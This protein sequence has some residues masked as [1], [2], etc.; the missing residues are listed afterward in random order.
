MIKSLA[1]QAERP[2]IRRK[3]TA[4]KIWL[5]FYFAQWPVNTDSQNIIVHISIKVFAFIYAVIYL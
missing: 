4:Y 5:L 3:Q 1:S 2:V